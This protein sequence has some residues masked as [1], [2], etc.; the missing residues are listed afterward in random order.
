VGGCVERESRPGRT[1][2]HDIT[3]Q[4]TNDLTGS[5]GSHQ[6]DRGFFA[7]GVVDTVVARDGVPPAAWFCARA[8]RILRIMV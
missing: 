1:L 8:F 6:R 2:L 4:P 3:E 7:F 5:H